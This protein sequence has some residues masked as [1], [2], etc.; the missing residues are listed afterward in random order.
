MPDID[1]IF[2]NQ[3]KFGDRYFDNCG[4]RCAYIERSPNF[5]IGIRLDEGRNTGPHACDPR[6]VMPVEDSDEI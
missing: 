3:L 1:D 6:D 4:H 2:G 5:V